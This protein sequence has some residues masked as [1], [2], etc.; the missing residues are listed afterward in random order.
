M[1]Q[2]CPQDTPALGDRLKKQLS[3]EEGS[4]PQGLWKGKLEK[5][6]SMSFER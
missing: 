5:V 2:P 1:T 4:Q 6:L 3:G